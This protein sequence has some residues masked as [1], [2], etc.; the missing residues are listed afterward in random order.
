M[1]P[2][3]VSGQGQ[4]PA[5]QTSIKAGIPDSVPAWGVNQLCAVALGYQA[6]RLGDAPV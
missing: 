4:N 3:D 5:R 1:K 6:V 2:E